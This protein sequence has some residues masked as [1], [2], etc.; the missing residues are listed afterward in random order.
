MVTVV[1]FS[2]G[3]I[4]HYLY[5]KNMSVMKKPSYEVP[6]VVRFWEKKENPSIKVRALPKDNHKTKIT[7]DLPIGAVNV[8]FLNVFPL[9]N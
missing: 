6:E 1:F 8:F 3:S 5:V 2:A 7:T 4:V 9:K